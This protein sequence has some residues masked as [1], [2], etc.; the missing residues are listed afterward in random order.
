MDEQILRYLAL[1]AASQARIEGYKA[2]NDLSK[3]NGEPPFYSKD[4]FDSEASDLE[5]YAREL[6]G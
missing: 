5:S 6:L 4:Y 2:R 3:I 1:I